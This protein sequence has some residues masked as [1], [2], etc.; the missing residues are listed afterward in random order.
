MTRDSIAPSSDGGWWPALGA[1]VGMFALAALLLPPAPGMGDSAELTLALALAGI[2]HPTGY[3]LYVLA[4][5]VFALAVHGLGASWVAASALW[6]AAGAAVALGAYVRLGQ[7]VLSAL[8]DQARREG[9]VRDRS[10]VTWTAVALPAL[11]LALNPIWIDSATV[12]EVYSWHHACLALS[13]AFMMGWLRRLESIGAPPAPTP[14]QGARS[15]LG[16]TELRGAATWGLLC[17]ACG[18]QHATA[19]FFVLPMTAALVAG[20]VRARRWHPSLAFVSFGAS[21]VPLASYGW[22]AWRALHP[23][24]FQW[25]VGVGLAAL[26]MHVR[27]AAYSYLL[28]RFSPTTAEW[29]L[30]RGAILP[31]ALPGLTLGSAFA[32]SSRSTALRWGLLALF[33]AATIQVAFIVSYGVPDPA[34]YF[35]PVLMAALLAVTPGTVL[36][37]RRV[38]AG[39]LAVIAL[40]IVGAVA[41]WSV[42]RAV[43]QRAELARVDAEFHAAW[44]A[45]PFDRGIVLWA[46]DHYHRFVLIQLLEG[47]RPGLYVDNPEML[48]WPGRR[49]AFAKRFGFDPLEGLTFRSEADLGKIPDNI[50]RRAHVPV[51]VIPEVHPQ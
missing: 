6:S 21:L 24:P 10:V 31:W 5:H 19:V 8:E 45:I 30:I 26:L 13:A 51:A 3:P 2:P 48:I 49:R 14:A 17:G 7:H 36:L 22:I 4:G 47:A 18:A 25:P 39:L 34:T 29:V 46:D 40:G 50:R 32:L 41:A 42:P 37:G 12:A 1:G 35:L 15:R 23:A 27:G 9:R 20:L 44:R 16:S 11:A 33:A 38:P 28:G 43:A